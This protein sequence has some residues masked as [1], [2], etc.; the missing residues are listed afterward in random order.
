MIRID[1]HQHF[2]HYAP[3]T[4]GWITDEMEVLK[5]DY[6]PTDLKIELDA[7]EVAGCV[8]VQAAQTEQET[9]FLLDQA[10]K[11]AFI[12]GVVGWVDLQDEAVAT[13]LEHW[14]SYPKFVGVRHIVQA[15]TDEHFLLRPAFLRG[16]RL[17]SELN[18]TYDLLI[19]E[20][21]LPVARS[22]V[23]QLPEAK[24]VIDHLAKPKIATHELSPWKE[25]IQALAE[26]PNVYC[27]L[28][29]LVTEADWSNWQP[30]DLYPYLDVVVEAFGTERVMVGSDWPVCLL[31]ASY[32]QVKEL[33][34]Q[35]FA[36]FTAAEQARVYGENTI[37]FYQLS[38][39]PSPTR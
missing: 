39:E 16:V 18:L 5:Q 13:R 6:L 32:A 33:M 3:A 15:E 17:L 7:N 37:D 24:L 14:T 35:Y 19:H 12:R 29:G 20:G 30:S 26:R 22:F 36:S 10:N 4:H 27:K 23:D 28:S 8:S 25:N 9:Q 21:Q 11:H 2:W 1:S 31:A 34:D 38:Y